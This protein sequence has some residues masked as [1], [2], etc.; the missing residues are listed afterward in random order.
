MAIPAV[1]QLDQSNRGNQRTITASGGLQI[2]VPVGDFKETFGHTLVGFSGTLSIP[3]R[4]IPLE[5]GYDF[6]WARMGGE[7]RSTSGS[8]TL[9][10]QNNGPKVEVSSNVYDHL[11][12]LRLSPSKS[13][14]RPYGDVL[15]GARHFV[16][17]SV[18]S[19]ADLNTA[20]EKDGSLA[21]SYGWALGLMVG[22][23][24][25]IYAEAR[26][27][28]LITGQISYVD[29]S[30]IQVTNDGAV[31]YEKLTSNVDVVNIQF[32]IGFRF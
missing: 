29:P 2:G 13:R 4:R 16:T 7:T 24:D 14:I 12:F 32:G 28:R 27:E 22:L 6:A 1:A 25:N 26:V 20:T 19:T 10:A 21:L 30:T 18:A 9:F 8:G 15:A 3:M 11:V 23:N 31:S 5:F 17:R